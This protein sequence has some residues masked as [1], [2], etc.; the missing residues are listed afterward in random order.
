[1]FSVMESASTSSGVRVS[2]AARMA[3]SAVSPDITS[4]APSRTM[5]R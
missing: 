3:V 1:M 5:R 4:G 2:P